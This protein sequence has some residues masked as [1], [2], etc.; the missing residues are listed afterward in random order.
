MSFAPASASRSIRSVG[1]VAVIAVAAAATFASKGASAQPN[2][3]AKI[4]V[5]DGKVFVAT[6]GAAIS[7]QISVENKGTLKFAGEVQLRGATTAFSVPKQDAV[8]VTADGGVY[9][10]SK[11]LNATLKVVS[12]LAKGQA[13]YT[14]AYTAKHV[15]YDSNTI[16]QKVFV[17]KLQGFAGL[18]MPML[19][20]TNNEFGFVCGQSAQITVHNKLEKSPG[21]PGPA[22]KVSVS[23]AGGP[24]KEISYAP[25]TSTPADLGVLDCSAGAPTVEVK[26]DGIGSKQSLPLSV[27][28]N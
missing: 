10:C 14:K 23:F 7:R 9:D 28:L 21:V 8:F 18:S 26:I 15:V 6:C 27:S 5:N 20:G 19:A 12:S 1:L 25:G 16:N 3:A 13:V 22:I 2:P 4:E 17:P 11:S 24:A